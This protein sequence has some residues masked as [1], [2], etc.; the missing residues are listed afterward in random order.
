VVGFPLCEWRVDRTAYL[1]LFLELLLWGNL[2]DSRR[3]SMK[4]LTSV[5]LICCGCSGHI[6]G[7]NT[8]AP[9]AH[10][11]ARTPHELAELI[12]SVRPWSS[13]EPYKQNDW[14]KIVEVAAIFQE[15]APSMAAEG[16][17]IFSVQNT[18]NFHGD[19]LE[20]S[21]AFLLLRVMFDLPEHAKA[22]S[23]GPG[24]LTG[25]R[26]LNSDG[27]INLAWPVVWNKG[28]PSLA[29]EYLGYEGLSYGAKSDYLFLN[30]HFSKRDLGSFKNKTKRAPRMPRKGI[31]QKLFNQSA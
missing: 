31:S 30:S 22:R 2:F 13:S 21:K 16:F 8:E 23:G 28:Q 5:I 19:F 4:L 9:D 14:E 12:S 29:S 11:G 26:D 18:N 20:D 10:V 17:E 24:W 25:R 15:A 1:W 6:S 27:T 7:V 3:G